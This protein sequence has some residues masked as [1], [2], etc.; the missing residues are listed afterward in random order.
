MSE[1]APV[2]EVPESHLAPPQ[3]CCSVCGRYGQRPVRA[4]LQTA[5]LVELQECL[6]CH[7]Q[8]ASR[9][10]DETFL[11]NLYAPSTYTSDL[12]SNRHAVRHCGFHIARLVT[13]A[14]PDQPLRVLDYGGGDGSLSRAVRDGLRRRGHRGLIELTVVDYFV[15]ERAQDDIRFLDVSEFSQLTETFDV[16]LASAVLEH[17]VDL[18][19]TARKLLSLC[20]PRG[21]FYARTPYE[22]P[23]AQLVPGYSIRWPR[24]L[25][26][27]GPAFWARFLE[28]MGF[29]G[30]MLRSAPSVVESDF[31]T[32]PLRTLIAR[33][34]KAPAHLEALWRKERV[35]QQGKL[36]WRWVG[37]W[38]VAMRI[39]GP[40]PSGRG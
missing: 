39:E 29:E 17:L 26:D 5:P 30:E 1:S 31:R 36:A 19:Y 24:H 28:T 38:E 25:H 16:V 23:L 11:K 37:G 6:A 10:P 8:T 33:A 15:D 2:S 20:T 32:R 3:A 14:H 12:F 21:F 35:E 34:L 4:T 7:A 27:L 18:S 40:A 22:M 9:L 13:A